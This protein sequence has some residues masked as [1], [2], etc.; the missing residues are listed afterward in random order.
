LAFLYSLIRAPKWRETPIAAAV[1]NEDSGQIRTGQQ[2]NELGDTSAEGQDGDIP[3]EGVS[4]DATGSKGAPDIFQA[5]KHGRCPAS[6]RTAARTSDDSPE[7]SCALI[8]RQSALAIPIGQRQ[9]NR[10]APE[11]VFS[12]LRSRSHLV[13]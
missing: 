11:R 3:A 10:V 4:Q 13:P 7:P 5:I 1:P 9:A 12:T 6:R 2:G 8:I